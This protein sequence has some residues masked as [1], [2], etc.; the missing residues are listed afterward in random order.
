MDALPGV[1]FFC[2]FL[3]FRRKT[4]RCDVFVR[5]ELSLTSLA[6]PVRHG[7]CERRGVEW[8]GEARS[9]AAGETGLVQRRRRLGIRRWTIGVVS[10]A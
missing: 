3:P 1:S 2:A 10:C 8:R 5:P 9:E 4:V 6:V 7:R